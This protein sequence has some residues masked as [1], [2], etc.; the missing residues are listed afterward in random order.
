MKDK[1]PCNYPVWINFYFI[2][3][4]TVVVLQQYRKN[5]DCYIRLRKVLFVLSSVT[6][7]E[8]KHGEYLYLP[9][10]RKNYIMHICKVCSSS[11]MKS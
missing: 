10:A 3:T 8:K 11:N 2:P 5:E 4:S 7:L 1:V 6:E 9:C